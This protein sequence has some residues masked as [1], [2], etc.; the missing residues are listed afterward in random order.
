MADL[1]KILASKLFLKLLEK[2]SLLLTKNRK[3]SKVAAKAIEKVMK[4]GSVKALGLV[5]IKQVRLMSM[6]TYYYARGIYRDVTK[7][8]IIVIIAVLL[9]FLMPFDLMPDFIPGLG[10]LDDITL[11]GW[12]FSTLGKELTQ[13]EEWYEE[14]KQAET[15]SFEEL[16]K[17]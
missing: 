1:K 2:A 7:K 4:T 13:F 16:K 9:Y 5:V 14:F 6:M 3:L 10:Y 8:S 17:G 12:L 15:I 11:I